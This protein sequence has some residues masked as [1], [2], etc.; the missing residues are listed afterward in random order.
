V[1][2]AL[3]NACKHAQASVLEVELVNQHGG[4][5]GVIG[6]D[7][8]GFNVEATLRRVRAGELGLVAMRERADFAGGWCRVESGATGTRVTFWIPERLGSGAPD[9]GGTEQ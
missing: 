7:G 5:L 9:S 3:A 1:Q 2:E 6:D 4:V 8:V